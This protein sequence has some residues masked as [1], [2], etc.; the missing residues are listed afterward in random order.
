MKVKTSHVLAEDEGEWSTTQITV[1]GGHFFKVVQNGGSRG[2]HQRG[3]NG[4]W[5]RPLEGPDEITRAEA[6]AECSAMG[7]E[8]VDLP[9]ED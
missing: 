8:E 2:A 1:S 5:D 9:D 6:L 3:P 4:N 7:V